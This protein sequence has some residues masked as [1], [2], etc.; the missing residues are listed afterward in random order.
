MK[1]DNVTLSSLTEMDKGQKAQKGEFD[2]QVDATL[3]Q[4]K[5]GSA[6]APNARELEAMQET[7]NGEG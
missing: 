2:A 1:L 4:L 3:A 7:S 6:N 5:P